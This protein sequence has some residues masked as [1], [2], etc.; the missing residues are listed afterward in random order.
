MRVGV[1]GGGSM[2]VWLRRELSTRHQVLIYDVDPARSDAGSLE[3]L[4]EW[5]EVVVVAV[6]FWEVAKVLRAL[7]PLAG[8]RLVMDIATFKEGLAEAYRV[9][10]RAPRRRL[11]IRCLGR[12]RRLSGGRGCW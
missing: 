2:G 10:R 3:E 12:G 5:A 1:V 6:P 4:V 11:C 8:G 7:A 9:S